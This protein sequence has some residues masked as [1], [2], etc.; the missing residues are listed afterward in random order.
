MR[1]LKV[2]ASELAGEARYGEDRDRRCRQSGACCG[3]SRQCR[4]V[5]L[6]C[7]PHWAA[8]QT[9]RAE[10]AFWFEW[11][12]HIEAEPVTEAEKQCKWWGLAVSV[13]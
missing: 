9:G 4:S 7:K 10:A 2:G 1:H 3:L 12:V 5:G 6:G 13:E 11:P 8:W